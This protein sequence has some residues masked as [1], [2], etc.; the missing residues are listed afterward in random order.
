MSVSTVLTSAP[1][2]FTVLVVTLALL[3]LRAVTG[4]QGVHLTR[5]LCLVLDRTILAAVV[6][7]GVLVVV[8]FESLA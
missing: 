3:A 7:F 8:R 1:V 5:R 4:E 2:L 6:L